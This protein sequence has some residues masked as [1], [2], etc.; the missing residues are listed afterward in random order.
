M[1]PSRDSN[2]FNQA[3]SAVESIR[4]QHKFGAFRVIR[5]PEGS[6]SFWSI[7]SSPREP[8]SISFADKGRVYNRIEEL[9]Q[10]YLVS[11]L[12]YLKKTIK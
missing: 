12:E 1:T 3:K 5:D 7:E 9:P 4:I 6:I 11:L 8:F 2:F 10:D